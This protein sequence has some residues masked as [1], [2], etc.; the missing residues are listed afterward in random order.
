[1]NQPQSRQQIWSLL[2]QNWDLI[3]IG[4]GITGAGIFKRAVSGGLKTLLLEAADFSSGT[5]S[6]SSKLVHGGFRYLRSGQYDV[7]FESVREREMLLRQARDLVTPLSFIMPY[8]SET[9]QKSMFHTGVIIYDLMAPKW[10]HKH[11]SQ[12]QLHETIPVLRP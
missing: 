5:S 6:K 10:N 2:D 8:G 1:M 4:G 11:L 9:G 12:N 3:I 7:T